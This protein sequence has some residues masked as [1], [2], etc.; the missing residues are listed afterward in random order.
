[1]E[2]NRDEKTC[3]SCCKGI[4]GE[5][6]SFWT[7]FGDEEDICPDCLQEWLDASKEGAPSDG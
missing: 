5:Y 1:M 3:N 7:A 2:I 6:Y 4:K